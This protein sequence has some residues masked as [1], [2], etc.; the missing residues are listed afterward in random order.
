MKK[1]SEEIKFISPDEGKLLQADKLSKN[2]RHSTGLYLAC[3][4][5]KYI[6]YDFADR[7]AWI[8]YF[9]RTEAAPQGFTKEFKNPLE[10]IDWLMEE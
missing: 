9:N 7:Q 1:I 4:N 2:R 10:A 5:D 6:A 3:D 8:E